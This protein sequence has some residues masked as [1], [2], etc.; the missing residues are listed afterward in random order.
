MRH[1]PI[2]RPGAIA[3][4]GV[5][6]AGGAP[7]AGAP[8][9]VTAFPAGCGPADGGVGLD[10]TAADGRFRVQVLR[11]RP[12]LGCLR[13][14]GWRSAG[15]PGDSATVVRPDV[16]FVPLPGAGPV[17]SVRVDVVFGPAGR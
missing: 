5:V 1:V 14:V 3:V 13:V 4:Y 16:F 7:L 6:F 15:T 2:E 12:G 9:R 8:V 17:D 10:T 11:A